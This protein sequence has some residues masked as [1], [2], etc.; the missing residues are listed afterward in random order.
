VLVNAEAKV[1]AQR[2]VLSLQLV[3]AD[4]QAQLEDLLGTVTAD[5]DVA[6]DLLVTANGEGADGV[7]SCKPKNKNK[8]KLRVAS[9]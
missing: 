5:G 8:M 9:D 4:L 3:L 2:E 7:A 6:S 1:A